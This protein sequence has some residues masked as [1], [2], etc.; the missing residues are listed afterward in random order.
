MYSDTSPYEVVSI[1]WVLA[2]FAEH[3]L[4]ISEVRGSNN[5]A[6]SKEA[7]VSF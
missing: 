5:E 7:A 1:I 6:N 2:Q 4:P 3:W